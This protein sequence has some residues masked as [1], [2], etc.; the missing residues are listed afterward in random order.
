MPI[1]C[2]MKDK[3]QDLKQ[4]FREKKITMDIL[5][6]A[7]SKDRV[8]MLEKY[9][10]NS[11]KMA[12]ARLEKAFLVPR[13]KMALRR[14]VYNM[15]NVT[16]LYDGLS[17]A[18][19]QAMAKGINIR[20]MRKMSEGERIET[21]EK[22]VNPEMAKTL[23]GFYRDLKVSGNLKLWEKRAFGTDKLRDDKRL[24]G[25]IS[26]IE[27]LDDLGALNPE[28]T[29]SF[30][31]TL[32]EDK[33]GVNLTVEESQKLS[34][35]T[36][37]QRDA[38]DLMMEKTD[39]SLTYENEDVIT[40]FLLK[41]Q[42]V[43]D[44][45]A[46]LTPQTP[47]RVANMIIDTMRANILASHR[48]LKN[49]FLY[50]GIP[51]IERAIVKRI[52]SGNMNSADM[53]STV[54]E[55]MQAKI[56]GIKPSKASGEFI[57]KQTAFAMRLYHKTGYDISRMEN[58]AE[59]RMFFGEKV[60]RAV[61]KPF[62]ESKGALEK[63]ASVMARI[64]RTASQAPKWLA[65]GTDTLFAN[66]GRA[67]TATMMSREIAAMEAKKGQLPKGMTEEQRADQLLKDS[68]SFTPV[69]PKAI[70]IR[71]AAIKDAHRMNGTQTD[72]MSEIV[73]GVRE[74]FKL[75]GVNFGKVIMPFAK[76]PATTASQGFQAALGIGAFN[77]L[78]QISNSVKE[79]NIETRAER[80]HEGVDKL[81]RYLG[82]SVAVVVI[83][84]LLDDDDYIA[85]YHA[86]EPKEGA[87][88][89]ARGANAGMLRVGGVWIPLRYLPIINIPLSGIMG[90]R[91]AR[92]KGES[93][94]SGYMGGLFAQLLETPGI[95]EANEIITRKIT[96]AAS[97]KELADTVDSLGFGNKDFKQWIKVRV[98]PAIISYDLYNAV[99]PR[100]KRYDFLGRDVESTG[101][102]GF[103][104]DK[105]NDILL[106]F[107]RL[108]QSNN[109]PTV[110]HPKTEQSDKAVST[111]QKEYAN[112]VRITIKSFEYKVLSDSDKKKEIDTL[113]RDIIL[114]P[115][116][117][118]DDITR[119]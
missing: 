74:K 108:N 5:R 50:Q 25:A 85:P 71:Y 53:K 44:Y 1:D 60:N 40:D 18:E 11:A 51:A 49:S 55:K 38:F 100:D 66:M 10:G 69:D 19:S 111:Y 97:S 28:D 78:W 39:G 23:N 2:I 77:A 76:I 87:L 81:V 21:L 110:S 27:A 80:M 67:D 113:R 15:F 68:Y 26:K 65:G 34:K 107:N 105:T 99:V 41:E 33:L 52:V 72:G 102:L 101:F 13:Q 17:I 95:K 6:E 84:A 70:H 8:A 4:A 37:A 9:I 59:G 46:M 64:S 90:L 62:R 32:V 88:A 112:Q 96:K 61:A 117:E 30:M 3:A 56:S 58:L 54:L 109:M 12:V 82:F 73:L 104:D 93:G 103:K 63:F 16:P 22:Y 29:A 86:L 14:A 98:L 47:S 45:A 20:A 79:K 42:A 35:L 92:A 115:L 57:R 89:R 7:T 48:I 83:A 118:I 36:D 116:R 91:Q 114:R 43:R 24:K 94:V 75:A 119:I 31:E 106:E